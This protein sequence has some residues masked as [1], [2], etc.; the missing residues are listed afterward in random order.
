[1]DGAG[2]MTS[3]FSVGKPTFIFDD[4]NT[5]SGKDI[6]MGYM[7]LFEGAIIGIRNPSAHANTHTTMTDAFEKIIFATHLLRMFEKS[8]SK[9]TPPLTL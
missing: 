6:Q 4:L 1:M 2:L 8:L 7:K 9:L 3:T 5:T